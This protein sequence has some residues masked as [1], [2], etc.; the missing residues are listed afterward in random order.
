MRD[1][2]AGSAGLVVD[3]TAIQIPGSTWMPTGFTPGLA[4]PTSVTSWT[5]WR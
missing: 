4:G 3:G 1:T 5:V 2:V